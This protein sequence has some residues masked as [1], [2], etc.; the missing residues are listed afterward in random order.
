MKVARIR[1][2]R[3][4]GSWEDPTTF[5]S[6]RSVRVVV[7]AMRQASGRQ[8]SSLNDH[9]SSISSFGMKSSSLVVI[10]I[11]GTCLCPGESMVGRDM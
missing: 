10:S 6:V 11:G 2:R 5:R 9:P 3:G 8:S 1:P 7:P 4:I